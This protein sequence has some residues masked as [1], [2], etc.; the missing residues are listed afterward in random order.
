MVLDSND[1]LVMSGH[2]DVGRHSMEYEKDGEILSLE[3]EFVEDGHVEDDYFCG[4]YMEGTGA[5]VRDY[6]RLTI[7][8]FCAF[9]EEGCEVSVNFSEDTMR[10]FTEQLI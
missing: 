7:M 3:Y 5:Y 8:D 10:K 4:G 6:A 1:Y 2:V 9:D